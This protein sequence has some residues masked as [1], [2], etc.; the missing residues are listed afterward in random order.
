MA[1][2]VIFKVEHIAKIIN[3]NNHIKLKARAS[4]FI[5]HKEYQLNF[6]K[7]RCENCLFP[8]K[9]DRGNQ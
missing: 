5:T 7:I 1:T 2:L 4:A 8:H 9:T 3:V 6:E